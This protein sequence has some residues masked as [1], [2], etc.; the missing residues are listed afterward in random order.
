MKKSL[1]DD[2]AVDT[3]GIEEL[4]LTQEAVMDEYMRVNKEAFGIPDSRTDM[5]YR[6]LYRGARVFG[7]FRDG[8][9][10]SAVTIWRVSDTCLA[11]ENVFTARDDRHQGLATRLLSYVTDIAEEKG[12][13]EAVLNVYEEDTEAVMLYEKL[14]Y[15]QEYVLLEMHG[16]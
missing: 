9:L 15:R 12:F 3:E 10:R 1:V 6:V 14:G 16:R 13:R 2:R 8:M 11:T 7:I 4:D 5:L